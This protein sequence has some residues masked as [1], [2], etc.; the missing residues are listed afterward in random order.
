MHHLQTIHGRLAYQVFGEQGEV[1]L[2]FHGFGQTHGD[3]LPMEIFRK[4]NQRFVFVDAFYH[5]KSTWKDANK[6]M[7]RKIWL[8]LIDGLRDQLNFTEF[9]LIGYSM[10]GKISLLIYEL[11][12]EKV[13]SLI[14]LSPDGIKTGLWYSMSNYP[15]SFHPVMKQ[16]VFKP[17]GLYKVME[18]L[19]SV[20]LI[21]SSLR[22]FFQTQMGTRSQRAQMYFTW[23][24][25]GGLQPRLGIITQ[26]ARKLNT[27]VWLFLG[28]FDQM[29]PVKN[30]K[31]F[32]SKIP[33]IRTIVLPV[34]HGGLIEA[35]AD[36]LLEQL[37]RK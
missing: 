15:G 12:A 26:K 30:L 10:G 33:Q 6:P 7:N 29:I 3:M 13:L 18:S 5:G 16:V 37:K 21:Q 35:T 36:Y 28:E 17:K 11:M 20:G 32:S 25:M 24:I 23:K 27:P 14:L 9:H 8:E 34:G 31:K 22:K 2:I 4:E 1:F 19:G